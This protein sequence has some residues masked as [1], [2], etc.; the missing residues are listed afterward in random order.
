MP[1]NNQRPAR[2]AITNDQ[3]LKLRRIARENP[4]WVQS[5]L[6]DWAMLEFGRKFKQSTLS[7]ILEK[8]Y[9]FLDDGLSGKIP[10]DGKKLRLAAHPVLEQALNEL[11]V[12]YNA[13]G[14]QITGDVI[15]DLARRLWHTMPDFKDIKEPAF[16]RGWLNGFKS[17]YSYKRH[18]LHGEAKSAAAYD[19]TAELKQPQETV[20]CYYKANVYNVDETALYWKQSPNYTLANEKQQGC[21]KDKS[22]I[23]LVPCTN[24]TGSHRL[25]L[26]AI[27]VAKNP[28][29]FGKQNAQLS[30][31]PIHWRNNATAWM[32]TNIFTNAS[33]GLTVR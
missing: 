11:L 5:K 29:A 9:A 17:R 16:S 21:K 13:K 14:L 12:K 2:K 3:R 33:S 20:S 6:A 1:I 15:I 28:R 25:Q 26:W 32:T 22:R 23:T 24:A 10:S 18:K 8:K 19:F 30:Q 31:L 7:E 4:E 27:G